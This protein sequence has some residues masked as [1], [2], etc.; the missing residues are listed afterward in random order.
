MVKNKPSTS[1][2]H[3]TTVP[4]ETVTTGMSSN[5]SNETVAKE[6]N[7]SVSY[8][9][10]SLHKIATAG[11]SYDMPSLHKI[12]AREAL[13][14]EAAS[15]EAD[16]TRISYA[17]L[18]T[19]IHEGRVTKE[20]G[21]KDAALASISSN[22]PQRLPIRSLGAI[23]REEHE[24]QRVQSPETY[25]VGEQKA[26]GQSTI[27]EGMARFPRHSILSIFPHAKMHDDDDGTIQAYQEMCNAQKDK[28]LS[29]KCGHNG[30]CTHMDDT[31]YDAFP[32]RRPSMEDMRH[33]SIRKRDILPECGGFGI[34]DEAKAMSGD[35][36]YAKSPIPAFLYHPFVQKRYTVKTESTPFPRHEMLK[37]EDPGRNP[38]LHNMRRPSFDDP[39]DKK[40]GAQN[41]GRSNFDNPTNREGAQS[42][43]EA[44]K[45]AE[46]S[47]QRTE[48]I[49]EKMKVQKQMRQTADALFQD[50]PWF[51]MDT[52][53]PATRPRSSSISTER[54]LEDAWNRT[55]G[56][57][58]IKASKNTMSSIAD[59]NTRYE[60]LYEMMDKSNG[61]SSI[62]TGNDTTS[63]G[64]TLFE[65]YRENLQK[66]SLIANGLRTEEAKIA[67][68]ETRLK[69]PED[70]AEPFINFMTENPTVWHAIQYWENKL[71]KAGFSKLSPRESW[72]DILEPNGKYYVNRN[73]TS[74][75][76]FSVGG[77]Y[78]SGN[79]IAMVAAH[80]D[81]LTAR[82]KP[83]STKNNKAGYVQLGV[84]PY[85]GALNETWWDRDLGI[86]GRVL[87]RDEKT[88]SI[89]QKLV[90]LGW[91]IARIPTLA[92]HFGVGMF[93]QN[94]KETQLV[95]IIGLDN[96]DASS[97]SPET[98]Q[99][100]AISGAKSTF[101]STQPPKLVNLIAK[102]L[103]IESKEAI[104][105]WELELFDTQP[106]QLGGLE[107]DLIFSGRIDDKVCSW[108]SIE[109]LISSSSSEESESSGII[110]MVGLFDDEEIGSLLRQGANS[111]FLPGTVERIVEC[112][113]AATYS[114][115]VLMETYAKSFLVSFDVTHATNP[116]FLEKYLENHAPRLNVGLTV[117]ADSNGHTTTDSVSTA[118]FQRL[119]EKC[120]QKLQTFMI[121]NDSRSGG[122]VGPMLSS[123][124]GVRAIDVG[125]P[126]LSMHSIRATTGSKDPGLGVKMIEG[127]FAGWEDVDAEF[128]AGKGW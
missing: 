24:K 18:P 37:D 10:P 64:Q 52:S 94:N 88:D 121:R 5:M 112:F 56:T 97:S 42:G 58:A 123:K 107:K 82:L 101:I 125:V 27:E 69:E 12:A 124:M 93:G 19:A 73:G 75:I 38:Y 14:E 99:T 51:P 86:G 41:F 98:F 68:E 126:Q 77:A 2:L 62:E 104:I 57:P 13:S 105:N 6:V 83:I 60:T 85:A 128:A 119:A 43:M 50:I 89:S 48:E 17:M 7:A 113:N 40:Y 28:A 122:T 80:S 11:V 114:P 45:G 74:L 23:A 44:D 127:V 90:K 84:A 36:R 67:K 3:K 1:S 26:Q 8:D 79:G 95:P 106:A 46:K 21:S 63:G 54:R 117:E 87:V 35:S 102:E 118:I 115:N 70:Y 92:P 33:P 4:K 96:S 16:R 47:L 29:G 20:M 30:V 49:L 31:A 61:S 34:K 76:A 110:S 22:K 9:M 108:S 71:E 91:P 72:N 111:N 15:K 32:D 25:Q 59:H 78:E 65:Q 120:G 103:G 81:S 100:S 39:V 116:N 66:N 53:A 109:A 55:Y